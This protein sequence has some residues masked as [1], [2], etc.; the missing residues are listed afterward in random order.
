MR[1]QLRSAHGIYNRLDTDK[2]GMP[3]LN[4]VPPGPLNLLQGVSFDR[5]K[6][7]VFRQAKVSTIVEV[8]YTQTNAWLM[9]V[10]AKVVGQVNGEFFQN[11]KKFITHEATVAD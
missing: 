8:P 1:D 2:E 6:S 4:R 10:L 11:L 7:A 9:A 5:V 3:C